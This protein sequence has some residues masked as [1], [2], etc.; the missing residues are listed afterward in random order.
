MGLI[1][2]ALSIVA[3]LLALGVLGYIYVFPPFAA[4]KAYKK[5]RRGWGNAT[6]ICWFFS[7][8]WIPGT[9]AW[10]Q[11]SMEELAAKSGAQ[12]ST[13][14]P[15]CNGARVQVGRTATY[16]KD[17]K[18]AW[19]KSSAT[20]FL[21]GGGILL[22]L[23]VVLGVGLLAT[24]GEGATQ[25]YQWTNG[26]PSFVPDWMTP[27]QFIGFWMLVVALVFFA[28]PAA[29]GAMLL[30]NYEAKVKTTYNFTC[31]GCKNRWSVEEAGPSA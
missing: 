22:V 18:K 29:R 7:V 10:F 27:D 28:G 1:T 16:R 6:L 15:A 9:I 23:C 8:G 5:G 4:R 3:L 25:L 30:S 12:G 24:G 2:G 17:G 19:T 21:V 13:I 26:K 14:C 11:P 31:R 20:I